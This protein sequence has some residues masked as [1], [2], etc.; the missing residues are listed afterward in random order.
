[1]NQLKY[2]GMMET[3]RIR[4]SGYPV[5]R[6]FA[7]FLF[8]YGMLG[9]NLGLPEGKE[10]CAGI[11][12]VHDPEGKDWQTGKTKVSGTWWTVCV[13]GGGGGGG[14]WTEEEGGWGMEGLRRVGRAWMD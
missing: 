6:V 14:G 10:K 8:R 7:D 2:S 3:V 11:M 13:W 9:R 4:R 5:R 1:M 12:K